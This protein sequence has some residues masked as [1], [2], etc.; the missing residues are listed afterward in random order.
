MDS[1]WTIAKPV[2]LTGKLHLFQALIE[3]IWENQVR[4]VR[5]HMLTFTVGKDP[6]AIGHMDFFEVVAIEGAHVQMLESL[7][8]HHAFEAFVETRTKLQALQ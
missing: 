5:H 8:E 2:N 1:T 6:N 7:R 4:R 3:D